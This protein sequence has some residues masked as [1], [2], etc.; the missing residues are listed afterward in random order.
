M[1]PNAVVRDFLLFLILLP[2]TVY[3]MTLLASVV[4]AAAR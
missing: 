1:T 2:A 4:L 3:V